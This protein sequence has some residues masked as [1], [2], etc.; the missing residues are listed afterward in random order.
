MPT[1]HID[2]QPIEVP[3]GATVLD[4]ARKVGIDIPALCY[5]E[6]CDANTSCM[7]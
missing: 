7:V 6:G 5:R 4:A 2:N 3:E 1:I